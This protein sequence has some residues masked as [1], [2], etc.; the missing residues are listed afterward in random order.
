MLRTH[1][2]IFA[3]S[4]ANTDKCKLKEKKERREGD[5]SAYSWN[6]HSTCLAEL[7]KNR[8]GGHVMV[9]RE[10]CLFSVFLFLS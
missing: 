2:Y 7:L 9:K 5:F 3:H 8:S 10:G 6:N 1:G 4:L